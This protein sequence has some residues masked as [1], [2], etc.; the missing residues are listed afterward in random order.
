MATELPEYRLSP[1]A[2]ED[3]E[4]IWIHSLSHWGASRAEQ[5]VDSLAVAFKRLAVSP[6]LGEDCESIRS[7]YRR[8]PIQRHVI[9]FRKI[10]FGIGIIRILHVRM[11]ASLHI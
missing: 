9:Y 7:G 6:A 11:Q 3:L 8:F 2:R 5:Y 4:A 10:E 1:K